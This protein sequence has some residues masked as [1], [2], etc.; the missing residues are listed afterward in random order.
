MVTPSR[1][2]R[3]YPRQEVVIVKLGIVGQSCL[4]ALGLAART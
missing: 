1:R 4:V 3:F 2:G